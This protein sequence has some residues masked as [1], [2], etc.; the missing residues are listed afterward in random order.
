[1]ISDYFRDVEL[2]IRNAEIIADKKVDFS[3]FGPD[4]GM[5]RGRLQAHAYDFQPLDS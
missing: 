5:L 3:K 1:V 4:E 2:R